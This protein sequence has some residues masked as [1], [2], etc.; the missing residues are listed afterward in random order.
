MTARLVLRPP[1]DADAD[2]IVAGVG[3]PAVARMLARVPL[4]YRGFHAED[5]IAHAR[6]SAYGFEVLG[7]GL[8][9][10]A[11]HVENRT[12]LRVLQKLGFAA[13]GRAMRSSLARGCAVPHI[14]TVLTRADYQALAR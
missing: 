5:F 9:R 6:Q 12:S 7:L 10:S 3:D 11:V 13:I 2:D 1:H 8:I 14:D 4:P